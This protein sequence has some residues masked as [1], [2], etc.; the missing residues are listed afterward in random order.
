MTLLTCL[1]RVLY[2]LSVYTR[3]VLIDDD[4]MVLLHVIDFIRYTIHSRMTVMIPT[5]GRA[6]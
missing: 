1:T 3:G 4:Y 2:A 5:P 6:T